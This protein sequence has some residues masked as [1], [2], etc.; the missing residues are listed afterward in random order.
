MLFVHNN[1]M[2]VYEKEN[3]ANFNLKLCRLNRTIK[4]GAGHE[5]SVPFTDSLNNRLLLYSN[6]F[7]THLCSQTQS[8]TSKNSNLSYVASSVDHIRI[9]ERV[10]V[11]DINKNTRKIT[12]LK[13]FGFYISRLTLKLWQF[14]SW[15]RNSFLFKNNCYAFV[16]LWLCWVFVAAGSS[17]VAWSQGCSPAVVRGLPIAEASIAAE[18]AL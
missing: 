1:V 14:G 10:C 2:S 17:P 9:W 18:H 8:K 4:P 11:C 16:Y 3:D 6:F 5:A 15:K 7:Y 12:L 13:D